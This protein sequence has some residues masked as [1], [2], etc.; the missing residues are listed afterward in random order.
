MA[1]AAAGGGVEDRKAGVGDRS[2][3]RKKGG[4]RGTLKGAVVV[5]EGDAGDVGAG[6]EGDKKK[7][8]KA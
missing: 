7:G 5:G 2:E 4:D 1:A 6:A 8:R 3:R